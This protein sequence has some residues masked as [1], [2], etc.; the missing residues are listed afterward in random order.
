[1]KTLL[2]FSLI[3]ISQYACDKTSKDTTTDYQEFDLTSSM[4]TF[5]DQQVANLYAD[6]EFSIA[7][8]TND[9]IFYYGCKH[10]NGDVIQQKNKLSLYEIG[11]ISKVFTSHLLVHAVQDQ[12]VTLDQDISSYFDVD[13][14]DNQDIT[15]QELSSHSSGLP[16]MPAYFFDPLID[17]INPYKDYTADV[18]LNDLE[19]RVTKSGET[20]SWQYSNYGVSILGHILALVY[21]RPYKDLLQQKVFEPLGMTYTKADR[22]QLKSTLLTGLNESGEPTANWDMEAI[23]PAGGIISNVRDMALYSIH[24][25]DDANPLFKMQS[26]KILAQPRKNTDQALGWMIYN[27]ASGEPYCYFHAGQTGGYT[28]ILMIHPNSKKSVTILSNFTDMNN[29][30]LVLGF[31]LLK[32]MING[33]YM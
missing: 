2:L 33:N 19:T 20:G 32:E 28:S 14:K 25:Y 7:V 9:S 29:T 31:K 21:K 26:Q 22:R 13:L 5:V 24:A 23:T 16:T 8:T 11:S 17:S 10:E 18:L 1:M 30:V 15:L 6:T 12:L 27:R 4:T 3:A